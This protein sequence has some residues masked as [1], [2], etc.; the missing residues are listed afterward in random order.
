DLRPTPA[1]VELLAGGPWV[2]LEVAVERPDSAPLTVTLNLPLGLGVEAR[3]ESVEVEAG[4][5]ARFELRA[6]AAAV[7][8]SATATVTACGVRRPVPV[9]VR[10]LEFR[11][12]LANPAEVVLTAGQQK[13]VD[14]RIDRSGGYAGPITITVP[15]S[16]AVTGPPV[17]VA[18]GGTSATVTLTAKPTAPAG[19]TTVRLRVA[20]ADGGVPSAAGSPDHDLPLTVRV[21]PV[22]EVRSFAGHAGKVTAAT[23]SADGALVASGGADGTVR[24]WDAATGQ[25]KWKGEGHVGAVLS[26]AF[27]ADAKHVV[28]GGVDKTVRAWDVATGTGRTFEPLHDGE[29]WLVRFVDAKTVTSVSADK[30]AHWVAATG[31]PRQVPDGRRDLILGQKYKPDTGRGEEPTPTARVPTDSG[32]FL[33]SGA[34]GPSVTLW[35]RGPS[36]KAPPRAASHVPARLGAAVRLAAAAGDG[37]RVLT[38]GEDN[39]VAV[40]ETKSLTARPVA[41]FPWTPASDVTCA[42][43]DASGRHALLGGADGSLKLWKLP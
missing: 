15:E 23:V 18:A 21:P 1:A 5:P 31:K 30:T 7:P 8:Q 2:P 3:K 22:A 27:S 33:V 35:R 24:L 11:A 19:A 14:V 34:G 32:E 6:A 41:G 16:A 26:V 29:V 39:A 43:L 13:A 40:W 12:A 28:S 42:A 20:A 25:E 38:V 10:R 17:A 36:E 9:T 37:S 4:A